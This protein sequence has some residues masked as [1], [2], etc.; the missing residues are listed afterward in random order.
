MEFD[1][2]LLQAATTLSAEERSMHALVFTMFGTMLL[3]ERSYTDFA[4]YLDAFDATKAEQLRDRALAVT[5][6]QAAPIL[7]DS[8]LSLIHI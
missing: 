3:P 5:T 4:S 1:S 8:C 7:H 2:W 6:A